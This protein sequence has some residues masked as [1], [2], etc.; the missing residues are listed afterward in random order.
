[1]LAM[2]KAIFKVP[3]GKLLKIFLEDADGKILQLRITGDFFLYPEENIIMLE[4]SLIGCDLK[5]GS[6]EYRVKAFFKH[7]KTEFYGLD[8][9]SIVLTILNAK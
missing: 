3:G 5:K 1:M 7:H 9:E 4:E 6:L 8:A 2:K